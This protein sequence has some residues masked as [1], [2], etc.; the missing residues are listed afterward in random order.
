MQL[1]NGNFYTNKDIEGIKKEAIKYALDEE[2]IKKGNYSQE[3]SE[4]ECKSFAANSRL[5]DICFIRR[6]K[7]MNIKSNLLICLDDIHSK[8][9]NKQIWDVIEKNLLTYKVRA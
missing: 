7:N 5:S 8:L 3:M 2:R 4:A 6:L 1:K 9:S